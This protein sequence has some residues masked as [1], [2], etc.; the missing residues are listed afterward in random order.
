MIFWGA[1]VADSVIECHSNVA[2]SGVDLLM[3]RNP[4]GKSEFEGGKWTDNGAGWQEH[5]DVKAQLSP[6]DADNGIFWMDKDDF[7]DN[8][9]SIYLS[10]SDMTRFKED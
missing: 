8:F 3:V 2:G 7:F 6:V 10:A 9:P 5:P 1:C 4:H